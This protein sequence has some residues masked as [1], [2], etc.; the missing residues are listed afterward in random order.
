MPMHDPH[1]AFDSGDAP[2]GSDSARDDGRCGLRAEPYWSEI[3]PH[4]RVG[5]PRAARAS[6]DAIY[7]LYLTYRNRKDFVGMDLA[8]RYLRLGCTRAARAGKEQT[9]ADAPSRAEA[10]A[11][12]REKCMLI[13]S[14]PEF[15]RLRDEHQSR[16]AAQ[17]RDFS[18]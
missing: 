11:L 3:R 18:T 9:E 7:A 13:R 8:R 1:S 14:D 16:H 17:P 12:F 4:W 2:R 6:A 5:S 10:A 15:R